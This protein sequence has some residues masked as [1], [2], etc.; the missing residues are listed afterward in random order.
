[1]G[2]SISMIKLC[3]FDT[4][5]ACNEAQH[6]DHLYQKA[7]DLATVTGVDLQIIR[8]NNLHIQDENGVFPLDQYIAENNANVEF[9]TDYEKIKYCWRHT[10]AWSSKYRLGDKFVYLKDHSDR[11]YNIVELNDQLVLKPLD[12]QGNEIVIVEEGLD[13]KE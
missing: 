1:M 3:E 10:T 6:Y 12:S 7:I 8:K 2:H 11:T 4:F 5:E 9:A 13:G